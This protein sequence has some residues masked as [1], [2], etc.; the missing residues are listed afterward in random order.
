[1]TSSGLLF[2]TVQGHR[3]DDE[4]AW[5]RLWPAA[6]AGELP[7]AHAGERQPAAASVAIATAAA[8]NDAAAFDTAGGYAA[9]DCKQRHRPLLFLNCSAGGGG[10]A[11]AG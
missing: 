11:D 9:L 5:G 10:A 1:M 3:L 7:I 2:W 6:K 4:L 8:A